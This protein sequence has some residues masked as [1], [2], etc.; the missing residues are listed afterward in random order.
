MDYW[1]ECIS[2]AFDDDGIKAAP[3]QIT[4]VA[5][6]AEGAHDNY[7]MAHGHD[8]I[9]NPVV[10]RE[11]E[12][13]RKL[14]KEKAEHDDWLAKTKPCKTCTTTGCVLD[15]WGRDTTCMDCN[16]EGRVPNKWR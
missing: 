12:E 7:R 14:K 1:V 5:N 13:L 15:G 10:T 11:N 16:G 6:W 3:E 4:V 9:P 8:H 2:E